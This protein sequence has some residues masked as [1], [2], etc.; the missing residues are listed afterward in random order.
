M[1]KILYVLV[2]ITTLLSACTG[3]GEPT[4]TPNPLPEKAVLSFPEQNSL[5]T[6]GKVLSATQS[7][8]IFKWNSAANT[9]SYE[10]NL[11]NLLTGVIA[12]STVTASQLEV[13]LLVTTPY[14]WW[15]VSKSTKSTIGTQSDT[16]KFYNSGPGILSYA[17]YPAE[18]TYPSMMQNVEAA[19]GSVTLN[20]LASDVD[21]DIISYDVYLGTFVTPGLYKSA[22]TTTNLTGVA[23][24]SGNV[25]YWKVITKDS[26]GNTSDS[27]L[28]QFKVN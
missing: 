9:D 3:G 20:W 24:L 4:P 8:L 25:Y 23:V 11:K 7:S 5:C 21:N 2:F 26:K 6:Q 19:D 27:G 13:N 10:F 18:I 14:S 1:R 12:T 16:W 17:P 28:F 22:I 15:V